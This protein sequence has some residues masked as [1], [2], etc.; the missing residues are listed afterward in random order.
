MLLGNGDGT[1]QPKTDYRVG[2]GSFAVAAGF[3]NDD[4]KLDIV[5]ADWWDGGITVRLNTGP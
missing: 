5:T 1:F 3:I 4:A 2:Q